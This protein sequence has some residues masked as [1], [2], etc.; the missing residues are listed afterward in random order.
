[1]KVS[2]NLQLKIQTQFVKN[3]FIIKVYRNRNK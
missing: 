3:Q 1:M 2:K